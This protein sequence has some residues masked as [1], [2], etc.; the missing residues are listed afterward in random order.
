MSESNEGKELVQALRD[1]K[2]QDFRTGVKNSTPVLVIKGIWMFAEGMA[3]IVT[4]LYAIR[5]GH[6]AHLPSWGGY[7]LTIA[8]VLVLVPA[9]VLLSKF[10]RRVGA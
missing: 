6:Y 7:A 4:S 8:G 5:Q 2:K 1:K 9:A 3:L 10:F